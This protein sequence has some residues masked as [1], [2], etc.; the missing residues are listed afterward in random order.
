M[1]FE[2][3][4]V[5]SL[6]TSSASRVPPSSAATFEITSVSRRRA[7]SSGVATSS[8]EQQTSP[9]PRR[10]CAPLAACERGDRGAQRR[11]PLVEQLSRSR[12]AA[13]QHDGR[14]ALGATGFKRRMG[15]VFDR[16]LNALRHFGVRD[17]G[18]HRQREVDAGGDAAD[19]VA[20]AYHARGL[21]LDASVTP[22]GHRAVAH[23][24]S[25]EGCGRCKSTTV[26]NTTHVIRT[27]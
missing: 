5:R 24:S 12:A 21:D 27:R 3:R 4:A 22:G 26:G 15:I 13:L 9:T 8:A 18:H 16:E 19:A 20:V 17:L 6:L 2:A 7:C 1:L 14:Y 25:A 11:T 23:S 10:S